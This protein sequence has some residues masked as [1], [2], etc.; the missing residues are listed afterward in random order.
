MKLARI[1]WLPYNGGLEEREN[2][3][4]A[5][6]S[7]SAGVT[8]IIPKQFNSRVIPDTKQ[9]AD[10]RTW[11]WDLSDYV[12]SSVSGGSIWLMPRNVIV[13]QK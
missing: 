9:I 10:V 11:L 4:L 7:K 2:M 1:G 13:E 3:T 5:E 12:V 8:P 6:W